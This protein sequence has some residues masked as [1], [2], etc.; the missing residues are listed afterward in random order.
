MAL[1]VSYCMFDIPCDHMT[2]MDSQFVLFLIICSVFTT[3][4]VSFKVVAR[5]AASE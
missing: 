5:A 1:N 2:V 3:K 4:L